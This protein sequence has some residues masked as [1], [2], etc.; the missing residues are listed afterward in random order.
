MTPALDLHPEP[1]ATSFRG[2]RE[3]RGDQGERR[4]ETGRLVAGSLVHVQVSPHLDH[5]RAIAKDLVDVSVIE[6]NADMYALHEDPYFW[7]RSAAAIVR[8]CGIA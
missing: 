7:S 5:E 6:S 2:H 4:C 8:G 3:E 1:L